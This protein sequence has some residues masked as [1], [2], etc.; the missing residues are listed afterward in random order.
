M[1]FGT[2]SAQM[3]SV[4]KAGTKKRRI[5]YQNDFIHLEAGKKVITGELFYI[6]DSLI[7]VDDYAIHPDSIT[8]V[9]DYSK[10]S[11]PERLGRKL[12][13]GGV[14]YFLLTT[15]NRA[16]NKDDPVLTDYNAQL[17]SGFVL[18]GIIVGQF[19]KRVFRLNKRSRLTVLNP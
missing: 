4:V 9:H 15:V 5:Y 2:A 10:G 6:S 19:K 8:K 13:A 12:I 18:S 17:S 7:I 11:F 1:L 14:F 3:I 16:G